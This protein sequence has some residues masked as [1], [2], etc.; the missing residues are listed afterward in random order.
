MGGTD[1]QEGV[2]GS[3]VNW[4]LI[5]GFDAALACTHGKTAFQR[6]LQHIGEVSI[7]PTYRRDFGNSRP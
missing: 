4:I 7:A 5:G 2:K 6:E 3:H 1:Q